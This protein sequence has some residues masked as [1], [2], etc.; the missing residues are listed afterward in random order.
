MIQPFLL[1]VFRV[2]ETTG[3][4]LTNDAGTIGLKSQ[5]FCLT[6]NSWINI[7]TR[8]TP[9]GE[10]RAMPVLLFVLL[11]VPMTVFNYCTPRMGR[12]RHGQTAAKRLVSVTV[13]PTSQFS[14]NSKCLPQKSRTLSPFFLS[15]AVVLK[16]YSQKKT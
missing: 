14:P 2:N 12:L 8:C 3:A 10:F 16:P 1:S 4:L 9:Y 15:S 6:M 11:E 7:S 13:R 5:A